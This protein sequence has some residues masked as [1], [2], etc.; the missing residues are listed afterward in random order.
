VLEVYLVNSSNLLETP[1]LTLD[2]QVTYLS[3]P[4][5]SETSAISLPQP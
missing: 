5:T 1:T 2:A 3:N 4:R